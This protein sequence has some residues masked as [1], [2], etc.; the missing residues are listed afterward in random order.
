[1]NTKSVI[2]LA[3]SFSLIIAIA[4]LTAW[5]VLIWLNEQRQVV[6]ENFSQ[7]N[8]VVDVNLFFGKGEELVAVPRK[9]KKDNLERN[10][11]EELLKGP[12]VEEKET[13]L[14]TFINSGVLIQGFKI[15]NKIVSV[16]FNERLDEGVAGSA[17][18]GIIRE[19]I[20]KTLLQFETVDQV[21]I[22]INDRTDDILQP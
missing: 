5:F 13:S 19:Q 4:L 7:R 1:M 17:L 14:V 8:E 20:E 18:V 3:V 11:L 6:V 2:V 16:D 10:T 12:S 9:V 15:E 21:I 22:S